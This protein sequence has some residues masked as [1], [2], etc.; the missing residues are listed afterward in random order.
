MEGSPSYRLH[1]KGGKE[2]GQHGA[3]QQPAQ[4]TR[5]HYVH[6]LEPGD[7]A[8]GRE[9]GYSGK[10][11][12]ADGKTFS[13]SCGC[14]ADTVKTVSNLSDLGREFGHFCYTSCVVGYWAVGIDRDGHPGY[15]E[16][17]HGGEGD[18]IDAISRYLTR[19]IGY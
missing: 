2:K 9:K 14:V 18:S 13:Y 17:P 8:V 12:R 15:G 7:R 4:N 19:E 16:H 5:I 10:Y 3:N 11:G 1:G 6:R